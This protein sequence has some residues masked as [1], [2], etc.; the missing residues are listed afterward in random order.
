MVLKKYKCNARKRMF[1]WAKNWLE[2]NEKF[3][4]W[5]ADNEIETQVELGLPRTPSR[6]SNIRK[7]IRG[8][9]RNDRPQEWYPDA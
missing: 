9:T 6:N 5:M 4:K 8:D 3:A 1:I 2:A 7:P